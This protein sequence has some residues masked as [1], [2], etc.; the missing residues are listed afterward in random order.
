[1]ASSH[2]YKWGRFISY[3]L[4]Q[5]FLYGTRDTFVNPTRNRQVFL[6]ETKDTFVDP[7]RNQ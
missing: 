1:M 3:R 2:E 7:T 4:R 6:Y 5:V